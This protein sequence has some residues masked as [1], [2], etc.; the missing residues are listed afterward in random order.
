M[1]RAYAVAL[2]LACSGCGLV[3]GIDDRATGA[4]AVGGAGGGGSAG[5]GGQ[6]GGGHGGDGGAG[7][8]FSFAEPEPVA[9][10]N[11]DEDDQVYVLPDDLV[12][13]VTTSRGN[14]FAEVHRSERGSA[15]APWPNPILVADVNGSAVHTV[16]SW[17]R[18]DELEMYLFRGPG[19]AF[20]PT[21]DVL[22]AVGAGDGTF[23]EPAPVAELDA[24]AYAFGAFLGADDY[25]YFVAGVGAGSQIFRS[26]R[27]MSE[28]LPP[29]PVDVGVANRNASPVLDATA[30]VLFFASDRGGGD[31]DVYV[32]CR[33]TADGSFG[34]PQPVGGVNGAGDDV[35]SSFVG[36][37]LYMRRGLAFS[38]TMDIYVAEPP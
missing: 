38:G 9:D 32:A 28:H 11:S 3:A 23:A 17:V 4:A 22:H 13:Y 20:P 30:T 8:T 6:A 37:R 14:G 2:A 15:R 10:L 7:C 35:P 16:A 29:V 1:R 31:F 36:G 21:L 33:A 19:P 26:H 25:V 12:A 27:P 5:G 18:A 34:A 24:S